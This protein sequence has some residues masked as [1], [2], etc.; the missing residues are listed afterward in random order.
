MV[1]NL[2]SS[3]NDSSVNSLEVTPRTPATL[4]GA[5]TALATERGEDDEHCKVCSTR[6]FTEA[7]VDN[8]SISTAPE[9]M[10]FLP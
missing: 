4:T 5:R 7:S 2:S 3:P 1:P 9:Q 8:E 10:I 6:R